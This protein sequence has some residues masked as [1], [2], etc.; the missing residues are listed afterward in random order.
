MRRTNGRN[1]E[2]GVIEVGSWWW[3]TSL[4][5][6][7]SSRLSKDSKSLR[8][9]SSFLGNPSRVSSSRWLFGSKFPKELE[10]FNTKKTK[11]V[12]PIFVLGLWIWF[13][14][15]YQR[16]QAQKWVLLLCQDASFFFSKRFFACVNCWLRVL[17]W[18]I[19]FMGLW[20][21]TCWVLVL[22]SQP[23]KVAC[24]QAHWSSCGIPVPVRHK[25]VSCN[26]HLGD[27]TATC[28]WMR[29]LNNK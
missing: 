29:T 13:K 8:L 19:F 1:I 12:S 24:L 26:C 14:Q 22:P 28:S 27:G 17:K 20:N 18:F 9:I 11:H 25:C 6:K 23:Q 21:L 5:G 4:V 7:A 2:A 16:V 10:P 15:T 3:L